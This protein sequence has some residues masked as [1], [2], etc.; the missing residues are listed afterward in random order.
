MI[1]YEKIQFWREDESAPKSLIWVDYAN[2]IVTKWKSQTDT[3]I[4]AVKKT[5]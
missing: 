5:Q 1:R 3:I 2:E 4:T